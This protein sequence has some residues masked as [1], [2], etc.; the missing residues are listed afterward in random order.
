MSNGDAQVGIVVLSGYKHHVLRVVEP[1][2]PL[3]AHEQALYLS[4]KRRTLPSQ[5]PA[6]ILSVNNWPCSARQ[7][8][9][10]SA[11]WPLTVW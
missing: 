7:L 10:P 5:R 8:R 9:S 11:A 6:Q 1:R 4:T 2:A 3:E